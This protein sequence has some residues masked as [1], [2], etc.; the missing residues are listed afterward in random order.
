[1]RKAKA[2]TFWVSKSIWCWHLLS[3]GHS[4][5]WLE[6][7]LHSTT[8]DSDPHSQME[9]PD[10]SCQH[11]ASNCNGL[12][13]FQCPRGL[14]VQVVHTQELKAR[15]HL[16]QTHTP[17]YSLETFYQYLVWFHE[18]KFWIWF[19]YTQIVPIEKKSS[20]NR[21]ELTD[22]CNSSLL[23]AQEGG[24]PSILRPVWAIKP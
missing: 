4:P 24:L 21:V 18:N 2:V 8:A 1:M 10:N 22:T 5:E 20:F 16:G 12:A 23:E 11:P 13:M 9:S 19:I 17:C 7:N 14:P 3:S 6:L 15:R